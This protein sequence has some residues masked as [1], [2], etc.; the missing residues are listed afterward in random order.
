MELERTKLQ[1][2]PI[3][4]HATPPI[5]IAR[6]TVVPLPFESLQHPLSVYQSLLEGAG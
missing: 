1:A 3:S 6:R 4:V 5:T 2:L